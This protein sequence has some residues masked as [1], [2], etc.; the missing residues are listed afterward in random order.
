MHA[1][2]QE[3]KREQ[4]MPTLSAIMQ[5]YLRDETLNVKR[6]TAHNNTMLR[7]IVR[8]Y[9][10]DRPFGLGQ[11]RKS[12][13]IASIKSLLTAAS[14]DTVCGLPQH[15]LPGVSFRTLNI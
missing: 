15:S 2:H 6:L 10:D 13:L 3:K 1:T 9:F 8:Y 14:H 4:T 12:K 7:N 11:M 5:P